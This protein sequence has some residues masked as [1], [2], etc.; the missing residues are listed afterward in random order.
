MPSPLLPIERLK[1]LLGT[2]VKVRVSGLTAPVAHQAIDGAFR[3]IAEIQKLMSFHDADSELSRLNREAWRAPVRINRH[4]ERVLEKALE[5][6]RISDGLFDPSVAPR[7][8]RRGLLPASPSARLPDEAASWRDICLAPDG[9]VGFTR[10]LWLDLGGIAKGYAVDCAIA[11]LEKYRP[12]QVCVEAGGD[13]RLSGS[14]PEQVCLAA[15]CTEHVP[16]LEVE[17]AAVASSG[18]QEIPG[19]GRISPHIDTRTGKS[20]STGRFVSVIAP[21]CMEADALTK[22]V[23]AAG[24]RSAPVLAWYGAQALLFE[25][26]HWQT[27]AVAA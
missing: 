10:P 9:M 3:L 26:A 12:L 2:F 16:I 8:V 25:D 11:L 23:M 5:I 18:S 15:P 27:L 20:C 13:L 21:H 24:T 22:V 19:R 7:L 1:P 17:K 14:S 6:A 4:T